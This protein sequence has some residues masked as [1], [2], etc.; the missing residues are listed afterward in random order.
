M[1]QQQS[2]QQL[3]LI[4]QLKR[5]FNQIQEQLVIELQQ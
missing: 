1:P 5:L 4:N 2:E 3:L